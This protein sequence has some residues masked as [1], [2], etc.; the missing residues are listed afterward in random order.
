[1]RRWLLLATLLTACAGPNRGA[2]YLR[3]FDAAQ[4]AES[5]GHFAD[6]SARYDEAARGALVPRDRDHARYLAARA[7]ARS[8]DLAGAAE[9]LRAIADAKPPLEDSAEAANAIAEMQIDRGDEDGWP[10]LLDVTRRF[11]SSGVARPALRHYLAHE[12]DAHGARA[13]LDEA[14]RLAPSFDGT[15]L[16]ETIHYEIALHYAAVGDDAR[17][18]DALIDCATR[19]PYPRGAFWDDSLFRASLLDEKLGHVDLA[20]ADLERMLL[21]REPSLFT[22]SYE[23]PR[24]EPA[25]VRLCALYRDRVHDAARAR[26][27][28]HR[29]YTDFTT[30]ELRDDALWEEARLYRE[31]GDAG[32]ACARLATLVHDFPDSRFVP[33]ALAECSSIPRPA[34]KGAPAECHDYIAT[35]RLGA[36]DGTP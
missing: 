34:A 30:S 6:A 14:Q 7:L 32:A 36:A 3:D 25:M 12:D 22:G 9:R 1:M 21:Q 35:V 2:T 13:T 10:A 28:F 20:I 11:P 5:A 17:A 8:G 27:C 24:Y 18:R 19:W 15:E 31:S 4:A 26:E 23:R 16:A 33:C 29:L